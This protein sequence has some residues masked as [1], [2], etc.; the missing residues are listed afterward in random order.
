[1]S[2]A[3]AKRRRSQARKN[4]MHLA[5]M[6]RPKYKKR[7]VDSSRAREQRAMERRRE[8]IARGVKV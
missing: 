1:M 7:D 4:Y 5:P 8:L 3:T 6:V 2:C